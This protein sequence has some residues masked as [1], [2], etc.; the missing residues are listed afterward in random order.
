MRVPTLVMMETAFDSMSD[1]K[2]APEMAAFQEVTT[3]HV[4]RRPILSTHNTW[5]VASPGAV[6]LLHRDCHGRST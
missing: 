6:P 1:A 3:H 5:F 2:I 4:P